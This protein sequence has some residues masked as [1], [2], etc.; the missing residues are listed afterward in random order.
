MSSHIKGF[1]I[2]LW[3]WWNSE[4]LAAKSIRVPFKLALV[5]SVAVLALALG[6]YGAGKVRAYAGDDQPVTQTQF[7]EFRS[8]MIQACTPPA[9][10]E[11][12]K[13]TSKKR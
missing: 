1:F 7:T 8:Q 5:G 13:K 4:K 11:P 3:A 6:L 2:E 12:V 9:K 10:V